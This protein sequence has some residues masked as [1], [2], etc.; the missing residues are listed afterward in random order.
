MHGWRYPYAKLAVILALLHSPAV[1]W[2]S[3][4]GIAPAPLDPAQISPPD[5]R[6]TGPAAA[7]ARI[8]PQSAAKAASPTAK[9]RAQV[10]SANPPT[11]QKLSSY[12]PAGVSIAACPNDALRSSGS[13][14]TGQN[15]QLERL[16]ATAQGVVLPDNRLLSKARFQRL[17]ANAAWQMGLLTLHGICTVLNTADAAVWFENAH[18]LGEPLAPAGLAWCEIEG[19]KAAANPAAAEKWINLLRATD[20]PRAQYLQ[21]LKQTRLAPIELA[22]LSPNSPSN[23][24]TLQNR[25]LLANAARLGDTNARIEMGL[26]SVFS[27]D[28]PQALA[29]FNSASARSAA[30][31]INSA[32]IAERLKVAARPLPSALPSNPPSNLQVNPA[33]NP[34]PNPQPNPPANRSSTITP[35]KPQSGADNFEQAQRYHKGLGVPS[36]YTEAIRLYQLAQNQGNVQARK[37]LE[38]IFSRPT[39]DG[40][41]NLVWM[42]Q[43]AAI[44]LS[45]GVPSPGNSGNSDNNTNASNISNAR[46]KLKREPTPLFDLVPEPWRRY[47]VAA[48]GA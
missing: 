33:S 26:E 23:A 42:Q 21:W 32:V 31:T 9:T 37:M 6:I 12:S 24:L 43:L 29:F 15:Q 35:G 45:S 20:A 38:L 47:G 25:Q 36:N 22:K 16:R 17:Q 18:A 7:P 5:I 19:C 3:A 27:N 28:L 39:A 34:Q 4:T 10:A 30:A 14:V 40:Q 1:L 11:A 44:D 41:I 46:Q 48:V 8:A 13:D 2:A